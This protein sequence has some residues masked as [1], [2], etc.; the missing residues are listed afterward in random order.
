MA[1]ARDFIK[2][3]KIYIKSQYI[4]NNTWYWYKVWKE[5]SYLTKR[6][7]KKENLEREHIHIRAKAYD[8]AYLMGA[9]AYDIPLNMKKVSKSL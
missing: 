1:I 7:M 3:Y 4:G 8:K 5:E 9:E 6:T 2:V